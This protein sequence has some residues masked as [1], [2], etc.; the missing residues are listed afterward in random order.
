[1]R[2]PYIRAPEN[3]RRS[4][5]RSLEERRLEQTCFHSLR[6]HAVALLGVNKV[7]GDEGE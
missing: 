3:G 7:E 1:V 2:P 6:E 4:T 5:S